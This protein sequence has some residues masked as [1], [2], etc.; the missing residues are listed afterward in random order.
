VRLVTFRRGGERRAGILSGD[1]VVDVARAVDGLPHELDGLIAGWEQTRGALEQLAAH[2]AHH[3]LTD[4]ELDL[5]FSP[6]RVLGT[7]G[8]YSDHLAEMAVTAPETPSAFLK[9]PGSEIGPDQPLELEANDR[10]VDYEGEIAAVIGRPVRDA[11]TETACRAI[12]GLMLANDISARDV[13]MPHATLAKG[14]RGFCPLG[15][16]LVTTDELDLD[17]ITFTV[18]VNGE[19][20]QHGHTG[21]LIHP[22]ADIVASYSRALPLEPGDVVL[23]GTPA[24]V[25]VGRHPPTFLRPGDEIVVDSPQ[26][27]VLRTPV[28][29]VDG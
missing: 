21:S 20:R 18:S 13:A 26:L 9:L 24:G 1:G 27:G 17:D 23:T 2:P 11:S 10:H 6:R 7:G 4:L 8:N 15:P 25:G 29:G 22:F 16:A 19:R 12:A 3:A 5:P 28:I 14:H